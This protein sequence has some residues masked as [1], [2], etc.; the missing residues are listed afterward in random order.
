MKEF[1]KFMFASMLG[2]IL[3]SVILFF[4]FMAFVMALVSFTQPEVVQVDETSVLHLKLNYDIPDRSANNP[5]QFDLSFSSLKTR[6]GLKEIIKCIDNAAGDDRIKGIYLDL[7]NVPSGLATLT[8]IRKALVEFKSSGK[9]IYAYGDIYFQKAYYMASVADKIF[10]NPQGFVE[11]KGFGGNVM[12]IK[13]LLEK[14]D[15]EPQVIRHG[16]YKSAIEPLILDQMSEQNKEQTLAFVQS[17]WDDAVNEMSTGRGIPASEINSI[18]DDLLA[19]QPEAALTYK[20]VDSLLYYDEFLTL[21]A[22]E[23]GIEFIAK[24]N[25]ITASKYENAVIPGQ[26]TKRSKNK[27]AVVY[28]G[29]DIVQGEGSTESIGG[30]KIARTIR[31]LRMDESVKAVVLRVNSP[32]GDGL[33]SDIILREMNLTKEVK[34]VVVSMGNL[35]A[36]GGYYISCGADKVL[37]H[38]TTITGSIGVFGLIPNFEGFFNNKMGITFDG[39]KTNPNADFIGVTSPLTDFQRQIIQDEIDRFYTTFV[40]HVAKGRNM[41][42]EAVDEIAQGRVWSGTDALEL[43]LIDEFGGLSQAVEVAA[44]LAELE[45]YRTVD[46]P[47]VK[48]P[49]EQIMEDLFGEMQTR[50]LK[51]ELGPYYRFYN[52]VDYITTQ[53]GIQARLPFEIE[54]N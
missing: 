22:D 50:Q 36:S 21:L 25:L 17:L 44:G 3:T 52:Y 35:A 12:F 32:G 39:V 46:Y 41:T 19:Q 6:P 2:F 1:F 9:F 30:A 37:A 13:G 43:G 18:A 24:A 4:L 51:E 54:I 42:F 34:P 26:Q 48:E 7:N 47:E 15:I 23:L 45:E 33:A 27:I 16:K 8:E 10:V 5:I 38:P 49:I 14:L 28:A 20:V 29:G 31:N 40:D 11:L 53:S